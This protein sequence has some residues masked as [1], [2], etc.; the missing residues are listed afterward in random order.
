MYD[1]ERS[2]S[3]YSTADT[4]LG[5]LENLANRAITRK[6]GAEEFLKAAQAHLKKNP[7]AKLKKL[8]GEVETAQKHLHKALMDA[9]LSLQSTQRG[10]KSKYSPFARSG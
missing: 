7:D 5:R 8:V 1:Y 10:P 3:A 2:K 4:D 6:S 9:M